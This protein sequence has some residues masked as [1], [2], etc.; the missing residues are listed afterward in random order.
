MNE[1]NFYSL[2]ID[3]IKIDDA[4]N[5]STKPKLAYFYL[6]SNENLT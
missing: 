6:R 2:R 1:S 4:K 3:S 5:T